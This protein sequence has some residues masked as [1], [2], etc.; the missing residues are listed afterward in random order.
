MNTQL[1]DFLAN[2]DPTWL[3]SI[4]LL[5][6]VSLVIIIWIIYKLR[7][8]SD[9]AYVQKTIKEI[10]E[11]YIKD[12]V[13]SDGLYGYHFIDYLILLP[14]RILV[15]AVQDYEGY[16]FGGEKIE[17]WAQVV[18]NRSFNFDN[19]LINTRHYIQAVQAICNDVEIINRVVFTGKSSFP[20]GIPSGVI[21]LNNLKKELE[22]LKGPVYGTNSAKPIWDRLLEYIKKEKIQYKQELST[23]A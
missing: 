18:N 16:I 22:N 23:A 20:K 9:E 2:S 7:H 4:G 15:L 8:P 5:A 12:A 13:L 11:E 14:G 10:S 21:E 19:P 1:P 3:A 17:K 6:A